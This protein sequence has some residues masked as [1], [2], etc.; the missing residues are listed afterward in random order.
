MKKLKSIGLSF[1]NCEYLDIPAEYIDDYVID[2]IYHSILSNCEFDCCG[3]FSLTIHAAA[4][5]I[6]W[7]TGNPNWWGSLSLFERLA[8]RDLVSATLTY[9]DGFQQEIYL[10]WKENDQE[11]NTY[12]HTMLTTLCPHLTIVIGPDDFVRRRMGLSEER[13]QY[14]HSQS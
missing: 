10:P 5:E 14:D 3:A 13:D 2:N 11:V 7:R 6:D 8:Y 4:N 9:E 1:E 12:H